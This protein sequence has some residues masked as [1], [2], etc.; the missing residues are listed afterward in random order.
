MSGKNVV[1]P[2]LSTMGPELIRKGSSCQNLKTERMV[3][4]GCLTGAVTFSKWMK[5]V[6]GNPTGKELGENN[7]TRVKELGNTQ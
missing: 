7:P 5:P 2:E 1:R 3:G 4:E 6:Y